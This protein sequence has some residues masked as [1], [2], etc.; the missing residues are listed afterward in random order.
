MKRDFPVIVVLITLSVVGILFIQMSWINNAVKLKDQEF[1]RQVNVSL[2]QAVES[3]QSQF[4]SKQQDQPVGREARKF[5]LE[6]YFTTQRWFKKDEL[7]DLIKN[8][9]KQNGIK[10]PFEYCIT[11]IYQYPVFNSE[12]FK[13][14]DVATSYS[15]GLAAENS[16]MDQETL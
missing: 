2:K 11:N 9:L 14:P 4:I 5:Y 3:I 12:G 16:D 15:M 8:V 10:Q 13:A 1:K 6:K 7:N